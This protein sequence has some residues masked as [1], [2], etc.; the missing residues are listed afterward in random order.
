MAY[1]ISPDL[2]ESVTD[3]DL[4]FGT[5]RLLPALVDIPEDFKGATNIYRTLARQLF[6]GDPLPDVEIELK[7]GYSP[8]I[9]NKCITAHLASFAPEQEHKIA[10]VAYMISLMATLQVPATGEV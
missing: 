6:Y 9:L 1:A 2:A 4:A 10:G 8:E 3:L 5:T 7:D